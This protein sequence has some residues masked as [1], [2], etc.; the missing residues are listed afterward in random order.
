MS[1]FEMLNN[2][3]GRRQ[4]LENARRELK[5]FVKKYDQLEELSDLINPITKFLKN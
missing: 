1:T 5:S 3:E 4:L 2:E